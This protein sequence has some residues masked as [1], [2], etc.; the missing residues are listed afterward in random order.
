M[1]KNYSHVGGLAP[2]WFLKWC[3]SPLTVERVRHLFFQKRSQTLCRDVK[4]NGF[5]LMELLIVMVILGILVGLAAPQLAGRT[6][7]AKRDA[8]KAD[9]LGGIAIA[10]D[11]YN[12]D[13]GRYPSALLD[14]VKNTA[15]DERWRGPYLK[16]GLPKDPWGNG[17]VYRYPGVTNPDSYDLYSWGPDKKE[18]TADDITNQVKDS[19]S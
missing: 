9:I 5:S 10:I 6:D 2:F 18:G 1:A 12:V 16:R 4:A 8:A 19:S 7:V 15:D 14:L 17:Y 3:L 11:L 13:M